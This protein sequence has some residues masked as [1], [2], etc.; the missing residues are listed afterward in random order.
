MIVSCQ[1]ETKNPKKPKIKTFK[2]NS[3]T[4]FYGQ[5]YEIIESSKSF[6]RKLTISAKYTEHNIIRFNK[7]KQYSKN[8]RYTLL[9]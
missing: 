5:T 3:I 8:E 4:A 9:E 2:R 6:F 1:I 7:A